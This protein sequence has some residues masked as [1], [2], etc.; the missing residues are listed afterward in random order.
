MS[1]HKYIDKVCCIA[2]A[3]VIALTAVFINGEKFGIET[4]AGKMGYEDRIFNDSYVHT[5]DIVMD[6]WESFIETCENEEY[7]ECAIVIDGESYKNAA[8]RAK[9]NT[10]LMQVAAYGNNRYSFKIEFDHYDDTK[11]YHGLDKLVLNNVIQDNTYMKDYLTYQ[12]MGYFGVDAPLCSFVYITVN[13]EEW[14]LYIAVEGVEE[15]FLER[16]YGSD[17]GE[18][19]KP[20]STNIGGGP[21]RNKDGFKDKA[22]HNFENL[23]KAEMPS[24][25]ES[26]N[27]DGPSGQRA[28]TADT[29]TEEIDI[30]N[31]K[32]ETAEDK[33]VAA[34]EEGFE[35]G[36]SETDSE[37]ENGAPFHENRGVMGG[38]DVSLIYT[39]DEFESYGNIFDNAKTDIDDAD[40]KRL[41]NSIKLLNENTDIENV[42]DVDE[43]IR[44]FVVH[45]FV[46]NF[47]S[48]TGSI[49]H[50]YYLYEKDGK[51]SMIPWDYN[52]A[53]GGFQSSIDA[54]SLIN[55]PIDTP[56]FGGTVESRPML[57]WI[58]AD[59]RY[60]QTYHSYF[61]EFISGY[62]ESG[63]F[64]EMM[65]SVYSMISPYVQKDPTKFCTYDEFEKGFNVLK[66]FS[67]ARAQ[68]I[69]G[70]LDGSIPSVQE[71]SENENDP[72]IGSYD[73]DISAMGSMGA[74]IGNP[75]N[76]KEQNFNPFWKNNPDFEN[77]E[78]KTENS[79]ENNYFNKREYDAV[80]GGIQA[81]QT[82]SIDGNMQTG[83]GDGNSVADKFNMQNG[84]WGNAASDIKP[85]NRTS[86]NVTGNI[87]ELDMQDGQNDKAAI[88]LILVSAVVLMSGLVTAF[89]FKRR[90]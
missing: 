89:K 68:S 3:A 67:I 86:L 47:D 71:G 17:Y 39:N 29:V 9:G 46:C 51:L 52:L 81:E 28:E 24:H 76:V 36:F 53:F 37:G 1:T 12:M 27:I 18:I 70:Q 74:G 56:V 20:D 22:Q 58:F 11:T 90:N 26:G 44:Y 69:R 10:S 7:A 82:V 13:G 64:E 49:I 31:E 34:V 62:F 33:S 6:D 8:I 85:K 5:L 35:H 59:E 57:A 4:S 42:V 30:P 84:N 41:I 32:G 15:S 38:D 54:E 45:N 87:P 88:I 19:Y 48:Y 14:G 79:T 23:M 66:E 83:G 55:Y 50:N 77:S 21:E 25:E 40:K 43:V 72:F 78:N 2:I 80:D 65:D 16:N 60:T 63:Y 75:E 73:I 61:D